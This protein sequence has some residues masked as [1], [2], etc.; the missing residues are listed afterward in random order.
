M[1]WDFSQAFSSLI[2]YEQIWWKERRSQS[3]FPRPSCWTTGYQISS[4]MTNTMD[5]VLP[6]ADWRNWIYSGSQRKY[7][8]K[9]V[10]SLVHLPENHFD[11]LINFKV[12]EIPLP[13]K[14]LPPINKCLHSKNIL[15]SSGVTLGILTSIKCRPHTH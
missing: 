14:K 1:E 7:L 15:L 8:F 5:L 11:G 12:Y 6:Q 2:A 13:I 4:S 10:V 9:I 3:P